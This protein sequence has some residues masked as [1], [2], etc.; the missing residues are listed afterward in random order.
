MPSNVERYFAFP[1]FFQIER[2]NY[3]LTNMV[4]AAQAGETVDGRLVSFLL[5]VSIMSLLPLLQSSVVLCVSVGTQVFHMDHDV[6]W[7]L[8]SVILYMTKF[9]G[10]E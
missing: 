4:K 7:L 2:C 6:A 1:F 9:C 5:H 3:F 8:Y 10:S